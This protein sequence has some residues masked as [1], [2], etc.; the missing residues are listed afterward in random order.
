MALLSATKTAQSLLKKGFVKNDGDHHFY[1]YYYNGKVVAKTK[2]SHND[3]DINDGLISKMYKQCQLNKKAE[4][5]DLIECPL[6]QEG[7]EKILKANK[8]IPEDEPQV[9]K[10]TKK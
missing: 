10:V 8:I 4:F 2:M 9:P 3:Q 5:M 1:L 7:Y 6:S